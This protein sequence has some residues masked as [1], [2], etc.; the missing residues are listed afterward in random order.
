MLEERAAKINSI[1]KKLSEKGLTS[2]EALTV[3]AVMSILQE[4]NQLTKGHL[5]EIVDLMFGE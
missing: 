1:C 3:I 4:L 5:K 2:E